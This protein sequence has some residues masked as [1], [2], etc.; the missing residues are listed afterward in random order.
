MMMSCCASDGP[1]IWSQVDPRHQH[2]F[3]AK[4]SKAG[5]A[6]TVASWSNLPGKA[7]LF[8][9]LA[10]LK[11]S[12]AVVEPDHH[13]PVFGQRLGT[14]GKWCNH[15]TRS[16]RTCTCWEECRWCDTIARA[17]EKWFK[18][19]KKATTNKKRSLTSKS[20]TET[21]WL[22][23]EKSVR[24]RLP[25]S[26][27]KSNLTLSRDSLSKSSQ[28][29]AFI[30]AD[31]SPVR[32]AFSLF[33]NRSWSS[34]DVNKG[35]EEEEVFPI[36][37]VQEIEQQTR[38]KESSQVIV[39]SPSSAS[40]FKASVHPV[41]KGQKKAVE[42]GAVVTEVNKK[43]DKPSVVKKS[44]FWFRWDSRLRNKDNKKRPLAKVSQGQAK[45]SETRSEEDKCNGLTPAPPPSSD[46][47]KNSS[48]ESDPGYESDPANRKAM[49]AAAVAAADEVVVVE[50]ATEDEVSSP[51]TLQLYAPIR[52]RSKDQ[53]ERNFWSKNKV[54]TSPQLVSTL[55]LEPPGALVL[56]GGGS[57]QSLGGAIHGKGGNPEFP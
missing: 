37:F 3:N 17:N 51:V 55:T 52:V 38:P 11:Q 26:G 29:L 40:A 6:N 25:K 1:L 48:G 10:R 42:T 41:E 46:G 32:P 50:A 16:C 27:S 33:R 30:K 31:P 13:S 47:G 8:D 49:A 35:Y 56:W 20:T 18:E 57:K 9:H 44:S 5:K 43:E 28:D 19:P 24:F 15:S 53:R 54:K 23:M 34:R 45:S 21:D 2:M 7:L 4:A 14:T 22:N 39:K 12:R 36:S